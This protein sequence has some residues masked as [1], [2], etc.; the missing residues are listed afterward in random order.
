MCVGRVSET[1]SFGYIVVSKTVH[2]GLLLVGNMTA[3]IGRYSF[4]LIVFGKGCSVLCYYRIVIVFL[5][6][7]ISNFSS[8]S[9]SLL[10]LLY[11][12]F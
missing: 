11:I 7:L 5:F 1:V 12:S 6:S 9:S 10:D 4:L 2:F 3:Y 8:S